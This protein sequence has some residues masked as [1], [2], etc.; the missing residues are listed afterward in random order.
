[1]LCSN[2]SVI[3]CHGLSYPSWWSGPSVNA[4]MRSTMSIPGRVAA[5]NATIASCASLYLVSPISIC[6]LFL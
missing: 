5:P 6:S 1:M 3:I 4:L 2:P